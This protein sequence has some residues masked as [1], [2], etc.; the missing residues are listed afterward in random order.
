MTRLIFCI[1]LII[2]SNSCGIKR[3]MSQ[4]SELELFNLKNDF[5]LLHYDCK[6]DVDDLHSV[7]AIASLI[8]IPKFANLN[9][10]A[11]AGTYG[12]QEGEYVPANSLF[13]LA[14]NDRWS[15]AHMYYNNSL[16]EV[17][18]KVHDVLISGGDIWIAEAGQSDFSAGLVAIIQKKMTDI[19]T[20]DRIHIVQH[21][22]WNENVTTQKN[23][24]YVKDNCKY[25]RIPDGNDLDNGSPGLST[26]N[27]VDWRSILGNE[28]II[29]IW[30]LATNL[31]DTYNGLEERYLNKSIDGG[32]MDFSDFCEVHYILDL[33]GINNCTEY[34]EFI[35]NGLHDK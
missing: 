7:A 29:E 24:I 28:E 33:R 15:D 32:G 11:V 22:A 1:F 8:R 27:Y 10:H 13:N 3:E 23:L 9:Y 30:N 6:T 4:E 2:A 12:I 5:L 14:F 34:F 20:K 19:N 31:A 18:L 17:Y 26:L 35:Q 25:H 16:N 21:S